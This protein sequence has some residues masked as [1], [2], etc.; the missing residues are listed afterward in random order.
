[1]RLFS[2]GWNPTRFSGCE[3]QRSEREREYEQPMPC[4]ASTGFIRAAE[5][6]PTDVTL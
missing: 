2:Q 1:M 4:T 5:A 3:Q 6:S